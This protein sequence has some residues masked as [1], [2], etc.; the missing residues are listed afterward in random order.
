MKIL[1]LGSTGMI[2]HKLYYHLSKSNK[3]EVLNLSKSKLNKDTIIHDLSDYLYLDELIKQCNPRIVINAAGLL[4]NDCDK[5]SYKGLIL[6]ALVPN[7]LDQISSH[8]N[9]KLIQISTDCVFSGKNGPYRDN[10]LPDE[11]S[12]YGKFK[13]IGEIRGNNNLTIRTSV[14][15]P[16][17]FEDGEELL[18]W[19]LRQEKK[20]NGYTKSIWSGVTTLELA[21]C[22]ENSIENDYVGLKNLSSDSPISKY[23]LLLILNRVFK[24]N[25]NITPID[26]PIHNKSLIGSDDF[27]NTSPMSYEDLISDMFE[28][29]N[30]SGL[31]KL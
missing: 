24:K 7:F 14:I 21:K 11:L 18:S 31:Y 8:R 9:F 10:E 15:G 27:Y 26:G 12:N 1:I 29:I 5:N 2:G 30:D 17:L 28:D 4:I 22:V 23:E 16:D 6:N 25:I 3:Y 20:I 19:F 13:S